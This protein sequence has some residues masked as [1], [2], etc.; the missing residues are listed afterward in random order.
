MLHAGIAGAWP[1]DPTGRGRAAGH[2]H[3]YR[4]VCLSAGLA[5]A[6]PVG[7]HAAGAADA[8]SGESLP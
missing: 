4:G 5:H 3:R 2:D 8:R 1:G 7:G 6:Y